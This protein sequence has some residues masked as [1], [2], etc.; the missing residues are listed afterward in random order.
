M[1][2]SPKKKYRDDWFLFL[3]MKGDL[4]DKGTA[5]SDFNCIKFDSLCKKFDIDVTCYQQK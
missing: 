3:K 4:K 2:F 1:A 5:N